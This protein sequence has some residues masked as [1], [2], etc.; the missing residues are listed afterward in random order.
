[1]SENVEVVIVHGAQ[2]ALGLFTPRQAELVVDRAYREVELLEE[3]VGQ[4]K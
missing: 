1:M 4:V 3:L 2:D